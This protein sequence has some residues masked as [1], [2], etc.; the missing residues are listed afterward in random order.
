MPVAISAKLSSSVSAQLS[1]TLLRAKAAQPLTAALRSPCTRLVCNRRRAVRCSAVEQTVSDD[2]FAGYKPTTAF[3]FPGQGAQYVGMAKELVE[4]C[5]AAAEMFAKA[6]DILGYDLLQLCAEGPAEKLNTTEISQPAIYVA[7]LAALEKLRASEGGAD[8]I[9]K[10]DVAGGLSLGEYTAL[11]FAGAMSFEDGLK[12]VQIR[13]QSMQAA[14]DAAPS[15]MAS[16]IGLDSTTVEEICERITTELGEDKKI[17][18]A[19]YLCPGNYAVSGSIEG[20]EM[21][22]QIAKPEYKAKMVVRLAVAGAFHT[23]Y[24]SP[25]AEK[26]REALDN[27]PI[28]TPR[29]PVIS[30]VDAQPHSDP[31]KIRDI[32][33]KQLTSAV[34]WET[35]LKTL[36]ELG[37]SESY[38]VGPGKVIAGIMKRIDKKASLTNVTA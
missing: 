6:N 24:M 36:L 18:V 15:G 31:A 14:A 34:L 10:V 12:L 5:P 30:N 1:Q 21:L 25:A 29:I 38:E 13:G 28:Q 16:V 3:L 27:T 17:Q 32:L 37:V 26:L 20:C 2:L 8:I 33:T 11:V 4:E 7:S 23:A 19:N 9:D 35:S 22:E